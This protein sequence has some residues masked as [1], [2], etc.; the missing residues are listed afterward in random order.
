LT[1]EARKDLVNTKKRDN[2]EQILRARFFNEWAKLNN[3]DL[4]SAEDAFG[5]FLNSADIIDENGKIN[6]EL[7][8]QI[9]T[10]VNE[11]NHPKKDLELNAEK[12]FDEELSNIPL[13]VLLEERKRRMR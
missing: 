12:I 4:N 6:K 3:K 8:N 7:Y 5:S 10:I 9:P 2:Y 13:K 1:P 11:Y